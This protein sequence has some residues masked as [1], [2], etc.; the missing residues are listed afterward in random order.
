MILSVLLAFALVACGG[1]GFD[2]ANSPRIAYAALAS[3]N[4]GDEESQYVRVSLTFDREIVVAE[5]YVPTIKVAGVNIGADRVDTEVS[6]SDMEVTIRVDRVRDGDMTLSLSKDA[7]ASSVPDITDTSG[8]YA[9]AAGRVKALIPSGVALEPVSEDG[10]SGVKV[11]HVFN[12]RCIAWLV[13]SDGGTVVSDS[14]MKG[15]DAL[16][17]A[18]ALHG[19]D[20]LTEDAYDVAANLA[21]TL[22]SH[23][24]DRY[25][26]TA[27]D[28]VVTFRSLADA[29]AALEVSLYGYAEIE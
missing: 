29:D 8:K 13:L 24:G 27:S 1:A 18:V 23:F 9:A 7:D 16:D 6:G 14:L 15:A 3:Y 5:G 11:T 4:E 10:R 28:T 20:F 21:D 26:F 25:E 19:H 12:I 17:G 22:T 2:E